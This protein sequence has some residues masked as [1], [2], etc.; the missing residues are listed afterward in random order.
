MCTAITTYSRVCREPSARPARV[1]LGA[2]AA[3]STG[4]PY[5]ATRPSARLRRGRCTPG[6]ALVGA[7]G[8]YRLLI[9]AMGEH[10]QGRHDPECDDSRQHV[11]VTDEQ[12][13][14]G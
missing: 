1:I 4:I 7:P 11:K 6:G 3:V 12:L 14:A 2:A 13:P 9:P 10:Q 5:R 8:R